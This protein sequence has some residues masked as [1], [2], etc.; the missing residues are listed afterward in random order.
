MFEDV[1]DA[2][3]EA[4]TPHR[5]PSAHGRVCRQHVDVFAVC[6][7]VVESLQDLACNL[8]TTHIHHADPL[9]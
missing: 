8:E 7:D 5:D 1:L 9:P 4:P 3:D 6:A 2:A